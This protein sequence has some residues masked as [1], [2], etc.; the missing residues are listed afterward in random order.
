MGRDE[1]PVKCKSDTSL[2]F[3]FTRNELQP[4]RQL[5]ANHLQPLTLERIN[6]HSAHANCLFKTGFFHHPQQAVAENMQRP[7]R[8]QGQPNLRGFNK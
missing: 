7:H 4:L 8:N 2:F 5:S 3:D 1:L 6:K